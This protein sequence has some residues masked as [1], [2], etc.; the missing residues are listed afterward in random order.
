MALVRVLSSMKFTHIIM[1]LL[2]KCNT[3]LQSG[4][5]FIKDISKHTGLGWSTVAAQELTLWPSNS[6]NIFIFFVTFPKA[7]MVNE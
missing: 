5:C 3:N 4:F 6:I 1:L 7:K 2:N